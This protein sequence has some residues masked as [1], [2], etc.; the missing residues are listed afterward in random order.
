MSTPNLPDYP[1][2][3]PHRIPSN[4]YI[5]YNGQFSQHQLNWQQQNQTPYQTPY[6][7]MRHI[8]GPPQLL[9]AQSMPAIPTV[10]EVEEKKSKKKALL[11]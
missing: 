3:T 8:E 1:P 10:P 6:G 5:D 9:H 11:W 7:S 4:G 2:Q